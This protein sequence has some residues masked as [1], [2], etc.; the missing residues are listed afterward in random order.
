MSCALV[1]IVI[2]EE[3]YIFEFVN[4]YLQIGFDKIYIYDN[5]ETNTLHGFNYFSDNKIQCIHFPGKQRQLHAYYH[6]LQNYRFENKWTA[7][8]DT[9]EFLVLR[10]HVN[11]HD[12]L[13]EHCEN[14]GVG[15][16]WKLFGSSNLL[17]YSNECVT[18]RFTKCDDTI[19]Q[20][21]KMIFRSDDVTFF[22]DPHFFRCSNGVRDTNGKEITSPFNIN[23]P[24]D[25]AVLH[26]YFTK[27][28]DEFQLKKNR[29]R[30]DVAEM[31]T[32]DD[33]VRHD[34]NKITDNSFQ[35]ISIP[36]T[37]HGFQHPFCFFVY[38]NVRSNIENYFGHVCLKSIRKHY[39]NT[40]VYFIDDRSTIEIDFLDDYSSIIHSHFDYKYG[41]N[42]CW[43]HMYTKKLSFVGFTLPDSSCISNNLPTITDNKNRLLD[44]TLNYG[45]GFYNSIENFVNTTNYQEKKFTDYYEMLTKLSV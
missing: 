44:D 42:L 39:P 28:Y 30:S 14:G 31:R 25:V 38:R 6:Y 16:N 40:H 33:F 22:A 7:F 18:K 35:N 26:H 20:H 43:Y 27:S 8:F 19:N 11:I 10:K 34:L 4:Y 9:D 36:K 2:H 29:G 32:N 13:N 37:F 45:V 41:P 17:H 5:S 1:L 24:E 21:I 3:P 23:G 12:F 15:I